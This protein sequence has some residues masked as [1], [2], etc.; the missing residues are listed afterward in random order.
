MQQWFKTA[1]LRPYVKLYE[2]EFVVM[3][4]HIH[5]IIWIEKKDDGDA[6]IA[7]VGARRDGARRRRAPTDDNIEQFGKPV[8]H[9]IPTIIRAYKSA[10]TYAVNACQN[11]RGA[12]LWQRNYYEYVIRNEQAYENIYNYILNNPLHWEQDDENIKQ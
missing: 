5:G 8:S 3:P 6:S 1:T 11:Q 2:D 9:S 10:V 4:N 12:V 7:I